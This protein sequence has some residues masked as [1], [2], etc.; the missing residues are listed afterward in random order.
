MEGLLYA[1]LAGITALLLGIALSFIVVKQI[2]AQLWYQAASPFVYRPLM[3]DNNYS[4]SLCR[5][6][7]YNIPLLPSP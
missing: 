6:N 5:R 3:E 2:L 7:W 1:V 4:Y